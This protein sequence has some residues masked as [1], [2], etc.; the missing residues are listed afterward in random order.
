MKM[1]ITFSNAQ[2]FPV[3]AVIPI[4]TNTTRL[5]VLKCVRF[6]MLPPVRPF[7]RHSADNKKTGFKK[8]GFPKMSSSFGN[9]AILWLVHKIRRFSAPSSRMVW[10]CLDDPYIESL[11]LSKR[12]SLPKSTCTSH[13]ITLY[14]RH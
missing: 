13:T 3:K 6:I 14:S 9:P 11:L 10:L 1:V 12:Y 4:M 7:Y 5:T 8:A 2:V